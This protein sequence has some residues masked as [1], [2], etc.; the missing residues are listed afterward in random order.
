MIFSLAFPLSQICVVDSVKSGSAI[1]EFGVSG[2][3]YAPEGFIY[4]SNGIQVF[5]FR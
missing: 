2:T 1:A 5:T 3:T 4:D